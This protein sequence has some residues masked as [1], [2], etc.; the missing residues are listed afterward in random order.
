M[1]DLLTGA[2]AATFSPSL[3]IGC[4]QDIPTG[5]YI[6]GK[7]G[8][9][10]LSGGASHVD[11]VC[12]RGNLYKTAL[13]IHRFLSIIDRYYPTVS[14]FYDCEDSMQLM[15]IIKYARKFTN[16]ILNMDWQNESVF[17]LT[18]GKDMDGGEWFDWIKDVSE[19]RSKLPKEQLFNTP[20]LDKH[21]NVIKILFPF[22]T[23]IDSFSM[24]YTKA[25]EK[26]QEEE[27]GDSKRNM[28]FM[29]D[30]SA[31][32]QMLRE[33]GRVNGKGGIYMLMTAHLGDEHQLD[34]YAPPQ[35]KLAFMQNKTKLKDVPEKFTFLTTNCFQ[36]ISASVLINKNT[37][38]VE[39]P[40]NSDDDMRN[41]TDLVL[42]TVKT[43]RS[44]SGP[45]GILHDF[46]VSQSEGIHVGLSEYWYIKSYDKYGIG[47]NDRTYYLEL[48][49]EVSLGRTTI[50]GKIDSDAKL[51]RALEITS[52]MCQMSNLWHDMPAG[53]LCS[54]KELYESLKEK[55]YDWNRLLETRGWWTFD[56]DKH[57][58][59]YLSTKDLLEMRVGTYHP[60]WY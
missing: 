32:T 56:N 47:G 23:A 30:G 31:K 55:G 12:G 57:P 52:E 19:M 4:L 39:Y 43:L 54:P 48:Y 21:G 5:Y 25:T 45:S 29:R 59:P 3:N 6:K 50:R 41:D 20:F 60:Y 7:Y 10:L 37:G 36:A 22:L 38:T 27:I 1:F 58:V 2:V 46:V 8:E 17:K 9:N 42:V 40:R 49:P 26:M 11:A 14:N 33:L 13:L 24:F 18:R 16:Y 35:K 15:R 28:E 53:L 44:K 51:R 34:P